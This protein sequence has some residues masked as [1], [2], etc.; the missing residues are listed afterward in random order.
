MLEP[1]WTKP[2][3]NTPA[4][5]VHGPIANA[6]ASPVHTALASL[7]LPAQAPVPQDN[8]MT[9]QKIALGKQ[10]YFDPRLS[11]TGTISCDSCHNAAGNGT[12]NRK[13]SQ[14]VNGQLDTPRNT[15]TVFNAAFDA[16]QFWDGRAPSLEAQAK[17]PI[18]NP[19]EM[20]MHDGKELA[21]RLK[22]IPGYRTAFQQVFG[23]NDPITFDNVTKAIAAYER[24]LL[25][26]DS[27]FDR[28]ARGDANA[29]SPA[30]QRGF[31]L[32]QSEG[33]MSCHS[34]A[35][36]NGPQSTMGQG[37]YQ[38]FPVYTHNEYV[39]KYHLMDHMGRYRVTHKSAD[40]HMWKVQSWRN[41]AL[42]APYFNNGSVPTLDEAVRVMAKT[43]LDKDLTTTQ[44]NEIVAFLNSLT[45]QFP[46][47][48]LPHLP[49]TPN[50]TLLTSR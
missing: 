37:S 11:S 14:G 27:P 49:Q 22:G 29:I 39:K 18:T 12:D 2:R 48:T 35:M 36:F 6:K 3:Q 42:T 31:Q 8:P 40:K 45:G 38:K 50:G 17:G 28:Y 23:G 26:P 32:V 9:P 44:V 19:K 47:Q 46:Q 25:T 4:P 10:L 21:N 24:T 30:A 5:G 33:C 1:L 16:V 15:P 7:A 43:Q 13:L 34:G 20:G 41:V